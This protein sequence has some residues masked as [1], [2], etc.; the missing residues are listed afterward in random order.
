M[1]QGGEQTAETRLGRPEEVS[2]DPI[3]VTP[4]S[5]GNRGV[6]LQSPQVSPHIQVLVGLPAVHTV[7]Q[8]TCRR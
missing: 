6:S 7:H 8:L 3:Q 4:G 1:L 5:K 2:G